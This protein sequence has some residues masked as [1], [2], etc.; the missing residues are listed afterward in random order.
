MFVP[1]LYLTIVFFLL[2]VREVEFM[3]SA[4]TSPFPRKVRPA[5]I[6]YY[7]LSAIQQATP[8]GSLNDTPGHSLQHSTQSMT[9]ARS[10]PVNHLLLFW[11][12]KI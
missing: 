2:E 7:T 9:P 10:G 11:S 6:E 1:N 4:S 3:K 12:R 5:N 8:W